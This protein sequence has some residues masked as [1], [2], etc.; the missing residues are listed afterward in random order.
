MKKNCKIILTADRT[1]MSNYNTSLFYGF[2]STAP[3]GILFSE[4]LFKATFSNPIVDENGV[5][6]LAPQG[7]R[8]IESALINSNIVN[9]EEVV[10]T[11]LEN[12]PR[13]LSDNTKIIGITVFD[14][15]GKGPASTTMSGPYGIVHRE[16]FNTY[17]FRRLIT[18]SIIK[19][20]RKKG[21]KIVIG[22]PGAWQIGYEE[23]KK[24][25]IDV[26]VEGEGEI[27]FP[28]IV[29]QIFEN[30]LEY[31]IRIMPKYDEIPSEEE[32][33]PLLGGTIG[34][35]VEVSRGCGRGC[36]FCA[37]TLRRLR[38][39]K[40]SDII[41]DIETNIR[42]GQRN[43][44][45]HAE[46]VL[47]YGTFS[48][49]PDHNKVVELFRSVKSVP[50]LNNVSISHAELASIAVSPST[51]EKISEILELD[52][53]H[54]LGFQTGIETGSK[55]LI[56]KYMHNKPAPFKPSEWK[57]VVVNAFSICDEYNWIPAATLIVNLPGE[58]EDDIIQTIELVEDLKPY[59]SF[60]CPLLYVSFDGSSKSMRF[61][62][63]AK[64][65]HFELYKAIWRHDMKWLEELA[66]DYS[67][68]NNP[69]VKMTLRMVVKMITTYLNKKVEKFL[70]T[71]II[72]KY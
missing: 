71:T 29:K 32:I 48:L 27:V 22:G 62:E 51:V 63:D 64:P 55:N 17:Y 10:V 12:I 47:R 33:P 67:K 40:I 2:I 7:L 72:Q 49:I 6:L 9:R 18:S 42:F 36:K 44:C 53:H 8:R 13:F 21:V 4:L 1:L 28:K 11:T 19:N 68:N 31:P 59:R 26:V 39:R 14:P 69:I 25:G 43:V 5:A 20:A 56:E 16:S 50:G 37:P 52:R 41:K 70:S 57:D 24:F 3:R 45:L 58:T 65:Y 61:I 23:M 54:W 15:F 30:S 46:D 35:L 38:H 60:L 66:N 34:G